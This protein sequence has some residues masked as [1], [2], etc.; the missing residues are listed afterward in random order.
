MKISVIIPTLNEVNTV[1]RAIDSALG[2]EAHE[3][4][5]VDGGSDDGTLE[6]AGGK[7]CRLLECAPGRAAQQNLGA[8]QASGEVLLF[9]HSDN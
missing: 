4:I 2:G 6:V 9:L 3:V 8:R 5:V 1:A 7:A